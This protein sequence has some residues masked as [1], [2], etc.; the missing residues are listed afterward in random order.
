[1]KF[2]GVIATVF[3]LLSAAQAEW[4]CTCSRVTSQG[5]A[6][7]TAFGICNDLKGRRCNAGN[8]FTCQTPSPITDKQCT[9]RYGRDNTGRIIAQWR[10]VC[11]EGTVC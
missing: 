6:L 3:G 1:M 9:E 10:A 5:E 2:F 8:S 7:V 11:E 4:H